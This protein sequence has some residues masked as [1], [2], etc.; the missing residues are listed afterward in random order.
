[1]E[2]GLFQCVFICHK[3]STP[4]IQ[5]QPKHQIKYEDSTR[6]SVGFCTLS[7]GTE[8]KRPQFTV[9]IPKIWDPTHTPLVAGELSVPWLRWCGDS[10]HSPCVKPPN[11]QSSLDVLIVVVFWSDSVLIRESK[12]LSVYYYIVHACTW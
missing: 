2:P 10:I 8:S 3:H 5:Q 12:R 9:R 11:T 4:N 6:T 7:Q 1:M